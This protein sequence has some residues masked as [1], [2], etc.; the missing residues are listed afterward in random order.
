MQGNLF[1]T[2][3][4]YHGRMLKLFFY[5]GN[6]LVAFM[7]VSVVFDTVMRYCFRMPQV[8]VVELCEYAIFYICFLGAPY[9]LRQG[10]HANIDIFYNMLSPRGQN[11][12]SAVT[13][14]FGFALCSLLCYQ[15]G[16]VA[17]HYYI[18]GYENVT[19]LEFPL[20]PLFSAIPLCMFLC[21]IEF[22]LW[23]RKYI[24]KLVSQ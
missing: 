9:L 13:S 3:N 15:T 2:I 19:L 23:A 5:I 17:W 16:K 14:I 7:L 1:K 24:G 12:L 21:A 4:E 22:I 20:W 6:L 11:K 10:R 8:W 18:K